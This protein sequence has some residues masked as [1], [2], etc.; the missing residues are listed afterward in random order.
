MTA[1]EIET[2]TPVELTVEQLENVDAGGAF[3][4]VSGMASE[5][6]VIEFKEGGLNQI[7]GQGPGR[8]T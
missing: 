8:G 3:K 6:E 4:N 1:R 2:S 7:T 5:T